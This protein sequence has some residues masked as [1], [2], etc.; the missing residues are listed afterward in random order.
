MAT[1][2]RTSARNIII[3]TTALIALSA[4]ANQK[5]REQAVWNATPTAT[6]PKEQATAKCEY[7]LMQNRAAFD[8]LSVMAGQPILNE[9]GRSLYQKC[10]MAQG[11]TFGGTVPVPGT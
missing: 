5:P 8:N 4:C 1:Y 9:Y 10:M 11:Y 3:V 2:N 7:D 6:A